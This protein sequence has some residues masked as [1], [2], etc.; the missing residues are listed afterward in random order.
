MRFLY[1]GLVGLD[2]QQSPSILA[3]AHG[4]T[5]LQSQAIMSLIYVQAAMDLEGKSE[6]LVLPDNFPDGWQQ[7]SS[8]KKDDHMTETIIELNLST[9]KIQRDVSSA[10]S[11]IGFD[12][13]DEHV[14]NMEEMARQGISFFPKPL[15]ILSID[16]ANLEEKIAIEV[17]GPA[18][19]ISQIDDERRDDGGY[20]KMVNGRL[21][22]QFRW[23]GD[24]QVINGPTALKQRL[25][26]LLGWRVIHLPFY[27]WYAL[28]GDE[29]AQEEYCR[30][31]LA[32]R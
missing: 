18:H 24:W 3:D 23:K 29:K 1:N 14:I 17:D 20:T 26:S 28:G 22:Y 32:D 19:F 12:H 31:L 10:F 6:G 21:E 4:D 9:S 2:G 27:E 30:H 15:E 13:V 5:G 11:R 8:S 16:I 7:S 25:L